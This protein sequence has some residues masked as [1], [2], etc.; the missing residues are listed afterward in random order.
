VSEPIATVR[1]LT[2]AY[3]PDHPAL[4]RLTVS[5]PRGATGLLGRNG[6]GKTSLL[7]A[8]LGFVEPKAGEMRLLGMDPFVTPRRARAEIGFAPERDAWIPDLNAVS[9]VGLCAQLA[10]LDADSAMGRAHDV[11]FYVGLGESR[12]RS[13]DTYSAGMR[14]RLKLAQALVHDPRLLILDEPTDGMDPTGREHML[15]LLEEI[16][17]RPDRHLI[18]SSH[19]LADI[20]RVCEHY[21][22]LDRGRLVASGRIGGAERQARCRYEVEIQGDRQAFAA[23]LRASG[24]ASYADAGA[25]LLIDLPD[26]QTRCV[27]AAA[28]ST[29]GHVRHLRRHE[30][31]LEDRIEHLLHL[32]ERPA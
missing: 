26:G 30:L 17:R 21:V 4:D 22:L 10:G 14:Q 9:A 20:E 24:I 12:Y 25:R 32:R 18:L 15:R 23:A 1:N 2:V 16:A 3:S 19:I 7:H 5:I 28:R 31:A 8:L 29:G 13:P 27:F 11:L 6:A